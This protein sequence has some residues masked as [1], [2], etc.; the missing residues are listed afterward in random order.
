MSEPVA[1]QAAEPDSNGKPPWPAFQV[2]RRSFAA[3]RK[4]PRNAR[5]HSAEQVR[6]IALDLIDDVA[7]GEGPIC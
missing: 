2:E 4:D 3:R 1:P 5:K 6:Q 7:A